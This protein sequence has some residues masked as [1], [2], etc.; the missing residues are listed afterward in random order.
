MNWFV[1]FHIVSLL[2]FLEGVAIAFSAVPGFLCNDPGK[3]LFFLGLSGVFTML[4]GLA[5]FLFTKR[6][7][8]TPPGLREGFAAVGLTWIICAVFGIYFV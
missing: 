5:G 4:C 1:T 6:K 8:M 7:D 2:V 3:E